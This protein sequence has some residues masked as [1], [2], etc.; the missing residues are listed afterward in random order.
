[1]AQ[2]TITSETAECNAV[3]SAIQ[4]LNENRVT[5]HMSYAML[6]NETQLTQEKVRLV[7]S[8]L[9]AAERIRRIVV[10]GTS[11][12]PRYYYVCSTGKED[13]GKESGVL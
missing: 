2:I 13:T 12:V 6:A 3:L 8:D 1:M 7:I 11:R 10:G 9:L 5:K 4:H